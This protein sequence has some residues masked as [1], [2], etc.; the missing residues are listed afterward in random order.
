MGR[1]DILVVAGGVIPKQDYAFLFDQ[2][3]AGIFGPG[4]PVAQ[5]AKAILEKL[6]AK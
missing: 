3:I 4:T 2:G 6:L 1:P 5:S